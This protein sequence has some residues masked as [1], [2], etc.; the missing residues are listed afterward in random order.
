ML[1]LDDFYSH[2]FENENEPITQLKRRCGTY[3]KM[4]ESSISIQRWDNATMKYSESYIYKNNILSEYVPS[5]RKSSKQIEEEIE[6]M[7][8]F[9]EPD[10]NPNYWEQEVL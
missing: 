1:D 5:S 3:I 6:S 9:L 2:V 7:L 10:T 8:P 4:T